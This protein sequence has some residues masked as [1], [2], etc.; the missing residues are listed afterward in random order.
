MIEEGA[1]LIRSRN[2]TFNSKTLINAAKNIAPFAPLW[3]F[4]TL[5]RV[6]ADKELKEKF[7]RVQI[8]SM[9]IEEVNNFYR[10]IY[11][12]ISKR[13]DEIKEKQ[14]ID[15][16][17]S[18]LCEIASRLCFR[19]KTEQIVELYELSID[20]H[21]LLIFQQ[22]YILND[23]LKSL[24]KRVFY[25]MPQDEILK[26]IP[27]LLSLPFPNEN[28]HQHFDYVEPMEEIEWY[29]NYKLDPSFDR[30]SWSE[31]INILID[32]IK[33]GNQDIRIMSFQRL[34]K[35]FN[36]NG[37]NDDEK[38]KFAEALW[39]RINPNTGLPSDSS[40]CSCNYLLLPE[41]EKGKAKERF[42]KL[43]LSS[44]FGRIIHNEITPDGKN[45]V[46]ISSK[47]D[48]YI[49]ELIYGTVNPIGKDQI[50]KLKLVDW[51][52]EQSYILLEK[53]IGLWEDEKIIFKSRK[54][55]S[56]FNTDYE[57]KRHFEE[58]LWLMAEVILP[59]LKET[60]K[61]DLATCML[62]EMM[63]SGV[64]VLPALPITLF[65]NKTVFE[66]DMVAKLIQKNLYSNDYWEVKEAL[67][68]IVKWH[69]NYKLNRIPAPPKYLL[70]SLVNCIVLRRQPGLEFAIEQLTLIIER[71]YDLL[72]EE[73]IQSLLI[74]LEYLLNE[75]DFNNVNNDTFEKS[76]NEYPDLR[77][78]SVKL[79]HYLYLLFN[80]LNKEIP[81]ILEKWKHIGET[82]PLPE[83]RRAWNE[84][85]E[86]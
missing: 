28:K 37:I 25:A 18:L 46:A 40:D 44:D 2:N 83:V 36:I 56:F 76:I 53:I 9:K 22:I 85:V 82:D 38:I 59:R 77:K 57:L 41:I 67:I 75:T 17:L 11:P 79:A 48:D 68:A 31:P 62:K 15:K 7:D 71:M 6:H 69:T 51:T 60:S 70:D 81:L 72:N 30:T 21:T 80:Q 39:S 73:Q 32:N 3:S 63:E 86:L 42:I 58:L 12:A 47:Q 10:L 13:L 34:A 54:R 8:A 78:E 43:I 27:E 74:A 26:K 16:L 49:F 50:V 1:L 55:T 66:V 33:N 52:S 45:H 24:F 23:S 4:V 20:M 5:F 29:K 14:A 65:F 61:Q 64:N 84:V 19:L 35:I